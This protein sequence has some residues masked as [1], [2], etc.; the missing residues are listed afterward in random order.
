MQD[1]EYWHQHCR[2]CAKRYDC[3]EYFDGDY[4]PDCKEYKKDNSIKSD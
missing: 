1:N 4:I 3:P 2:T